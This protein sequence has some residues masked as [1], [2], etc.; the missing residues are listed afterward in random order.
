MEVSKIEREEEDGEQHICA[1]V[2]EF[3]ISTFLIEEKAS[4][5]PVTNTTY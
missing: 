5:T 3:N 4:A 1:A 2:K